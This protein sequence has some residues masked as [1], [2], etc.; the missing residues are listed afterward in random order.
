MVVPLPVVAMPFMVM[1][2]ASLIVHA[3]WLDCPGAITDGE[4]VKEEM[5]GAI[6]AEVVSLEPLP[7]HAGRE[8]RKI[9]KIENLTYLYIYNILPSVSGRIR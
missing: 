4:A 3:N 6:R 8:R 5:T 9:S 7:L 2:V 1:S